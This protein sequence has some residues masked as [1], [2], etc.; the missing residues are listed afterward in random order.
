[1]PAT[2]VESPIVAEYRRLTP[3]SAELAAK[4]RQLLPSG[5]THDSRFLQPYPIYVAR[6]AGSRKWDVDGREYVDYTGG[7]GALLFGHNHPTIVAAIERQ[8]PLGTH[9]GAGHE[10]EIVW[11]E[12]VHRLMPSCECV[13]FTSSGT[14]ATHLALRLARAYTG[15]NKIM[16]FAGHF[17]GWHDH[18]AFGVGSHFDGRPSIGVLREVADQIVLAPPG[19]LEAVRSLMDQHADLAAVIIEPTGAS[20][21][22]L[23]V[24][25]EFLH[26]LRHETAH[27]GSL[28]IFDEV[29]S[30][31]RCAP[32]GAQQYFGIRPDLTTLAKILAGGLPG[33]AVGGRRDILDLLSF[34]DQPGEREKVPHQGTYNA[35]PLSAA[36]GIAALEMVATTDAC[37]RANEYGRRLRLALS[38]VIRE[39]GASWIVYGSFSGFHIWPNPERL[40]LS[41][42][43]IEAGHY[44]YR[45]LKA[46]P[47]PELLT[48]LRLGMLI[49]GVEIFS[50]PGG[51]TSAVHTDADLEQTVGAFAA[52]L[53]MLREEGEL[54]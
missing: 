43:Q 47:R 1:M 14:E 18:M 15:R 29:I 41:A 8:L 22:Q 48:K 7:H 25:G 30:G 34:P 26:A 6:A 28:L 51:P 40:P 46:R 50:W 31:F 13:R 16:R 4:A 52:T 23:P 32:G 45:V 5:I 10:Q 19:D 38:E 39:Q 44:D 54:I 9:Y 33:G 36:A 24:L 53:K 21:G 11:A 37:A 20:W 3:R 49:H 2:L 42:E 27:R 35:N 17:H 12:W